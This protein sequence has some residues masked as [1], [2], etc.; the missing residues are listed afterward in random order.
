M[1]DDLAERQETIAAFR[2]TRARAILA[3]LPLLAAVIVGTYLFEG[4][5]DFQ[6]AGLGPEKLVW[7]VFG[8]GAASLLLFFYLWRCPRCG[9]SFGFQR[10][11]ALAFCRRCGAVFTAAAKG[12][13]G[14]A[15]A[16][17]RGQIDAA[18]KK[19]LERYK[20]RHGLQM[21]RGFIVL[22]MG[23]MI[24]IWAR[25][26][27]GPPRPDAVLLNRLG[28]HGTTIVIIAIGCGM[29]LLGLYFVVV[30]IRRVT[31]GA[32]EREVRTRKFLDKA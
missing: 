22:V 31:T 15:A 7:W 17:K 16:Q 1:T 5:A 6:I 10:G 13:P 28:V 19:D 12:T 18:V 25:P 14:T 11:F 9:A 8:V 27:E 29:A 20:G 24:A 3:M 26:A 32:V 4:N 30:S 23:I 21:M 2:A